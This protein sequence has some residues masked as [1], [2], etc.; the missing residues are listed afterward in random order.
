M[1]YR[2]TK[3]VEVLYFRVLQ[4]HKN[5]AQ[6]DQL[7]FWDPGGWGLTPWSTSDQPGLIMFM[8]NTWGSLIGCRNFRIIPSI[9]NGKRV[10]KIWE[11]FSCGVRT[12]DP[13]HSSSTISKTL[14]TG[15]Y[16]D[17]RTST[18]KLSVPK[19]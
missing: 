16:N 14:R 4:I 8:Q 13:E 17:I 6:S 10:Q 2:K 5:S 7:H 3:K 12:R 11:V 9:L 19:L 18:M 1:R 15:H